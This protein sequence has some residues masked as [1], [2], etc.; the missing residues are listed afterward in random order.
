MTTMPHSLPFQHKWK[1]LQY[2]IDEC[3][4]RS[5]TNVPEN[6]M[7]N[8]ETDQTSK[9]T[10]SQHGMKLVGLWL[11][12]KKMSVACTLFLHYLTR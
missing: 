1:K 5:L 6:V 7:T 9:W 12:L 4:N 8:R 10:S 11:K 2:T 3:T